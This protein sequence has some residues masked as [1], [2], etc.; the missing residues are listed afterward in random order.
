M[1]VTGSADELQD[2]LELPQPKKTKAKK[3][4]VNLIFIIVK[5]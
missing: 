2:M 3:A 5:F 1:P 4:K